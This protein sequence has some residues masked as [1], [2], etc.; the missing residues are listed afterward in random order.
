MPGKA[1]FT[2]EEKDLFTELLQRYS[3]VIESKKTDAVSLNAKAKAW[4]RLCTEYNSMPH[5]RRRE[6]K[7]LKKLWDNLKQKLK[8]A[9]AQQIRDV[10]ATGGGPLPEPLDDRLTRVEALVPHVAVRVPNPFDSDRQSQTPASEAVTDII[11]SMMHETDSRYHDSDDE[12]GMNS[13]LSQAGGFAEATS[14]QCS[15]APPLSSGGLPAETATSRP[16]G[17]QNR[18]D[19]F[20]D[21]GSGA[22]PVVRRRQSGRLAAV[23]TAL[24]TELEARLRAVDDERN[25]RRI[26]HEA[27][28]KMISGEHALKMQQYADERRKRSALHRM[29]VRVL[30]AKEKVQ[31]FKQAILKKQLE[32]LRPGGIAE[33]DLVPQD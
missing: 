25:Q 29:K 5:V 23:D 32:L 12:F 18:E 13:N 6:V 10:M 17:S 19:A 16:S 1:Y 3:N 4:E 26:E 11:D 27:R 20:M 33:C 24:S 14:Q 30:K 28:M 8:K 15:P 2:E 31:N 9:K 7:Q 22:E 21:Q